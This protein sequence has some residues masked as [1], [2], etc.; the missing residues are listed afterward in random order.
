MKVQQ[1][2]QKLVDKDTAVFLD[3]YESILDRIIKLDKPCVMKE[4]LSDNPGEASSSDIPPTIGSKKLDALCDIGV[5]S[6]FK[7]SDGR[8]VY[9]KPGASEKDSY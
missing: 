8:V 4:L 7:A 1:E 5:I 3:D 9:C 6:K 2:L